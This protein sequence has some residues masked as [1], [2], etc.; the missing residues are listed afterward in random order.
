MTTKEKLL[1]FD[2]LMYEEMVHL[3]DVVEKKI[4]PK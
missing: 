4:D 2:T 3:Y 1:T